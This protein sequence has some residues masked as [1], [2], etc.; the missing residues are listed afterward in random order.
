MILLQFHCFLLLFVAFLTDFTIFA[1]FF[2]DLV[3][4]F[5]RYAIVRS[6]FSFQRYI[7]MNTVVISPNLQNRS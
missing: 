6:L 1:F 5:V 4:V 7:H 2:L 3:H